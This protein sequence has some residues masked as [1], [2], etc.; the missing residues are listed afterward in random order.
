MVDVVSVEGEVEESVED[1]EEVDEAESGEE[2][3]SEEDESEAEDKELYDLQEGC[4]CNHDFLGVV[5]VV[6]LPDYETAVKTTDL[7]FNRESIT[8][9]TKAVLKFWSQLSDI[10]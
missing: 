10:R 8:D 4:L 7:T 1:E 3:E 9:Y 2:E 6:K 5:K